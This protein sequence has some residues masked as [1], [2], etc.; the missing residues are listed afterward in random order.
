MAPWP[1]KHSA[2]P[3]VLIV[4]PRIPR[5]TR[6]GHRGHAATT[7]DSIRRRRCEKR[8][9][10]QLFG[11]ANRNRA[12]VSS[13]LNSFSVLGCSR[14]TQSPLHPPSIL[15]VK[16]PLCSCHT[17]L[18]SLRIISRHYSSGINSSDTLS[19]QVNPMAHMAAL[20][21]AAR[22]SGIQLPS[23]HQGSSP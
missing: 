23:R 11:S 2:I 19:Y 1:E 8:H 7:F 21:S 12:L 17:S 6:A 4:L 10:K 15:N 3:R 14:S 22:N 5:L 13:R 18:H 20:L 16:D 9:V